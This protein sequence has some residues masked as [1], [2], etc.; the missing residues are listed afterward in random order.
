MPP[1]QGEESFRSCQLDTSERV[2]ADVERTDE[3]VRQHVRTKRGR[4]NKAQ[5]PDQQKDEKEGEDVIHQ[6]EGIVTS[7]SEDLSGGRIAK[8][9]GFLK[10]LI[11][12]ESKYLLQTNN[13]DEEET[14]IIETFLAPQDFL[15]L[16][17]SK[18]RKLLTGYI[19]KPNGMVRV[20]SWLEGF[21]KLMDID[22][23]HFLQNILNSEPLSPPPPLDR[24][25][26]DSSPEPWEMSRKRL[27]RGDMSSAKRQ[28]RALTQLNTQQE[29]NDEGTMNDD[30]SDEV[31]A[32]SSEV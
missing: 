20:F 8:F 5:L 6:A 25:T 12:D 21:L 16:D 7:I 10:N 3:S 14:F 1:F 31:L 2:N 24:H 19:R 32:R 18:Q 17:R 11:Q 22:K 28:K 13:L 26:F 30:F 15:S 9:D 23:Y 27:R 4:A 29:M